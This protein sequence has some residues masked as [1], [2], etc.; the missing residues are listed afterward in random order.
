[1]TRKYSLVIEG[2]EGSYSAYVPELPS[3][4]VTGESIDELTASAREAV[5]LYWE[6]L[7][8]E[9]SPDATVREIEVELPA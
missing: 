8:A 5:R 7:N 4:V 2:T 3:V 1:M 9:K 6:T